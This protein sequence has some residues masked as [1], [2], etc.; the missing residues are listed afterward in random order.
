VFV[1]TGCAAVI[2][3]RVERAFP[4]TGQFVEVSG[5]RLHFVDRKPAGKT[6]GTVVLV[7]GA[8]SNH[9]DLLTTLGPGLKDFRVLAFDRPGQGWSD[10]LGGREMAQPDAQARAIAGALDA[11]KTGPV[12]LVAHSLAGGLATSMALDRPD[13]V[14][15]LV[16]LAA[17]T[18]P[19]PGGIEWYYTP[20]ATPIV[21]PVFTWLVAVPAASYVID[22]AARSV[23]AP[24]IPPDDY[25]KTAQI[26]LILRPASFEANAQDVAV[27]KDFVGRQVPRYPSLKMPVVAIASDRDSVVS[28]T[29]HSAA[30]A[31]EAP[32]GRLV[33]INGAG[34][35][36]H[37]AGR[38][39]VVA[40]IRR[41]ADN[42][43]H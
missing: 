10:R 6:R 31:R 28:P 20:A 7:H 8:S 19:W 22:D 39:R 1:L 21:G 27:L 13:L 40:E 42:V 2:G 30:I 25:V 9:A 29:I 43:R 36:P 14:E 34:H 32:Q 41:M 26:P 35:M 16:L 33:I 24:S 15:G 17:V 23:F 18:H 4:P 3:A 37:H 12:I 11:L 5:G 38:D